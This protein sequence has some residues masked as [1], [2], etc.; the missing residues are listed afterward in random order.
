MRAT[1]I[2][3]LMRIPTLAR[4][5]ILTIPSP[6]RIKTLRLILELLDLP[7]LLRA[8]AGPLTLLFLY[9]ENAPL[10]LYVVPIVRRR[11]LLAISDRGSLVRTRR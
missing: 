7:L 10:R 4:K 8:S 2:P 9:L 11:T 1:R 6:V 5:R 3:T